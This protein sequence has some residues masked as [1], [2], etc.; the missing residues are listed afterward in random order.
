[1]PPRATLLAN[2]P[3]RPVEKV[4]YDD[5]QV[6]LTRL[7]EQEAGNIPEGWAYGFTEAQ[8]EYACA[9]RHDHGVLVVVIRL[10]QAMPIGYHGND[11]NRTENVGQYSANPWGFFDMHGNVWEWTSDG[12]VIYAVGSSDRSIQCRGHGLKPVSSGVVS[13]TMRAR[14]WQG[15]ANRFS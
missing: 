4:S 9:G 5:I 7:N 15:S 14:S 10:V 6:F 13:G 11:A 12:M 3:D 8:W 2:N 1:M